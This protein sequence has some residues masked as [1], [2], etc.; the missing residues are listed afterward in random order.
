MAVAGAE[1]DAGADRDVAAGGG[2]V[3]GPPVAAGGLEGG[4]GDGFLDADGDPSGLVAWAAWAASA[5]LHDQ[6]HRGLGHGDRA[7]LVREIAGRVDGWIFGVS[8]EDDVSAGGHGGEVG[9][10]FVGAAPEDGVDDGDLGGPL[11]VASPVEPVGEGALRLQRREQGVELREEGLDP[12]PGG[13]IVDVDGDGAFAGVVEEVG[14]ASFVSGGVG[15]DCGFS[16]AEVVAAGVFDSDDVGADVG[17]HSCAE[18]EWFV[19]EVEDVGVVE[20]W[21]RI[22]VVRG[23]ESAP[24]V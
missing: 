19:G 15:V 24:G 23:A 5:A 17:E 21:V 7:L 8:V 14:P 11:A 12:G 2:A 3:P 22:Y 13:G 6:G 4:E 1:G 9:H 10:G 20:H 16:H 18:G